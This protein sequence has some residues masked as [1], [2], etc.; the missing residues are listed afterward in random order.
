MRVLAGM[1]AHPGQDSL[2]VLREVAE[3]VPW[4]ADAVC[5]LSAVPLDQW[6][7]EHTRLFINGFPRTVCPPFASA[8]VADSLLNERTLDALEQLYQTVSLQFPRMWVDYLGT[9]LEVLAYL[10]L[11]ADPPMSVNS[12]EET[13]RQVASTVWNE[14]LAPWLPDFAARLSVEGRLALYRV[15][16][17]RLLA[18]F[19]NGGEGEA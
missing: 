15:L 19:P 12:T 3:S 6:Q 10:R 1:L 7:A 8:W 9:M 16:G 13:R 2:A 14:H 11:P 17:D 18:L 4:L 5:E